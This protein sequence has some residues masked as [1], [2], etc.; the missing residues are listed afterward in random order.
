MKSSCVVFIYIEI[1]EGAGRSG[2][3]VVM[4]EFDDR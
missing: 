2:K 4:V 3:C 1:C